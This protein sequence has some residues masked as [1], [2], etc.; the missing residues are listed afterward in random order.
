MA[1][2]SREVPG[3]RPGR[4]RSQR[5]AVLKLLKLRESK[6]G[7]RKTCY[8]VRN[9]RE[10]EYG[11][12]DGGGGGSGG[13][14]GR[15]SSDEVTRQR[16]ATARPSS[17]HCAGQAW[18]VLQLQLPHYRFAVGGPVIVVMVLRLSR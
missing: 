5:G 11:D 14:D 17:L 10:G 16:P 15:L 18:R 1:G 6:F 4:E 3:E 9:N 12:G 2:S 13:R 8:R 7:S